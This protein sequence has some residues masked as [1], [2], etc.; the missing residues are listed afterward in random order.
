[1][2]LGA[3]EMIRSHVVA[4]G[5][6]LLL[7]VA[8]AQQQPPPQQ[9]PAPQPAPPPATAAQQPT[10]AIGNLNLQDA[11]LTQVIDQFARLLKIN[12]IPDPR[13]KG[14]VTI[15]TYGETRNLDAR[16]VLELIL[17][18]NDFGMV[19]DGDFYRIVPLTDVPK[20]PIRIQRDA[21]NI[22]DDDQLMLNMIF[23]KYMTVDELSNVLKLFTGDNA[24]IITYSP[25]NLLFILDSHRNMRRTMELIAQFDSDTFAN[26][27]VRLFELQNARPSDVVKELE[28]ILKA[29]SLDGKNQTVRF[30]PVDRISTIIAVAPNPGVFDT[31][32]TWLKKLDVP[33]SVAT[34]SSD[35]YVYKVRYGRAD[36]LSMALGQLFGS[37][38]GNNYNGGM[39]MSPY[40]AYAPPGGMINYPGAYGGGGGG[41]GACGKT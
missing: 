10:V 24:K 9:P 20:Q 13:V 32:E 25:A 14:T 39:G 38:T 8:V 34:G 7:S 16:N 37:N 19:Q 27:R 36:C 22:P 21:Q 33:V 6:A 23:L 41:G 35:Y 30:L 28:N 1:M 29:V 4:V 3:G 40:G 31:V 2:L 12:I 26:E 5:T 11:S 18:I 15:N 17:R